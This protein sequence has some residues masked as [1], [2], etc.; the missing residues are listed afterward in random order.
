MK[1]ASSSD[2]GHGKTDPWSSGPFLEHRHYSGERHRAADKPRVAPQGSEVDHPSKVVAVEKAMEMAQRTREMISKLG[3]FKQAS[4]QPESLSSFTGSSVQPSAGFSHSE[5]QPVE[6]KTATAK[7]AAAESSEE[8]PCNSATAAVA[9]DATCTTETST[10]QQTDFSRA[11]DKLV[12]DDT[13]KVCWN[14]SD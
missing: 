4:Q 3:G 5:T 11:V 9:N 2:D 6:T 12:E 7:A 1:P 13:D 14:E 10:R 8:L